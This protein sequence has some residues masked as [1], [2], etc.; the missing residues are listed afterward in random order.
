MSRGIRIG[1]GAAPLT[2]QLGTGRYGIMAPPTGLAAS[3]PSGVSLALAAGS[4]G[5]TGQSATL[6]GSGVPIAP[7]NVQFINQGGPNN[8]DD[9]NP[10]AS[11]SN[12]LGLQWDEVAGALSYNIYRSTSGGSF[13]FLANV[14]KTTWNGYISGT[15]HTVTS[16]PAGGSQAIY[17][18]VRFAAAGLL[19]ETQVN[20]RYASGT[21]TGS[22]GTYVVNRSQTLFSSGSPGQFSAC[23]YIDTAATGAVS[24]DKSRP[25]VIY[26]YNVSAVN[27][28]GEGPQ[29]SNM[30]QWSYHNG[31]TNWGRGG[32][33]GDEVS[34]GNPFPNTIYNSTNGNPQ[35]GPFVLEYT[36][37][38]GFQPSA[39]RPQ[40]PQ[41]EMEV[42]WAKYIV[43][44]FNPGAYSGW[45]L[46]IGVVSGVPEGDA[47]GD[48]PA[49]NVFSGPG[50]YGPAPSANTWATYKIPIAALGYG[51][52][53]FTGSISNGAGGAGS[54]VS[55]TSVG[56]GLF[57]SAGIFD[58]AGFIRGTGIP[59]PAWI[60]TRNSNGSGPGGTG[61]GGTWTVWGGPYTPGFHSGTAVSLNV[62]SD[63]TWEFC[64]SQ[65][66]KFSIFISGG[67]NQQ[68]YIN[69]LGFSRT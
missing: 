23:Y 31:F 22:T 9:S 46:N 24:A 19:Q 61:A 58:K 27:A 12:I 43:F 60:H 29:S 10:A 38:G 14:A 35:G 34:F 62:T 25:G 37:N 3:I 52:N 5:Y 6:A 4:Y 48:I 47:F 68:S 13:T 18:C 17:P 8:D 49:L 66:Y 55:V 53:S 51:R 65:C 7:A 41:W 54:T 57:G 45:A 69:N 20:D 21:G 67:P 15:T 26:D 42:G 50:T 44:D 32:I 36:V 63:G 1:F 59:V 40:N 28:A 64:K 33:S 11:S 56:T 39:S 30:V 16:A 2:L